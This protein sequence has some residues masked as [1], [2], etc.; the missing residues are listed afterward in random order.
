MKVEIDNNKNRWHA[1]MNGINDSEYL[2]R[3]LLYELEIFSK[4]TLYL[5]SMVDIHDEEVFSFLKR[6]SHIIYRMR[7]VKTKYDDIKTLGRFLWE[8][9]SGWSFV[10]GYRDHDIIESMINRI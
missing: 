10:E 1:I 3:D 7:D 5:L 6:M 2:L 9:F 4:E 8:I